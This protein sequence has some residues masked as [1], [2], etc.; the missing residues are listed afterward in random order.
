[1]FLAVFL[2]NKMS[3]RNVSSAMLGA[4][5]VGF[6]IPSCAFAVS[7]HIGWAE[8]AAFYFLATGVMLVALTFAKVHSNH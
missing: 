7:A 3:I 1:M 4:V 2:E 6:S 8:L 5:V